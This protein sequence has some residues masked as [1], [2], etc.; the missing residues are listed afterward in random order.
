MESNRSIYIVKLNFPGSD[1]LD[2]I[3]FSSKKSIFDY[4]GEEIIGMTY[5]T[6]RNA[7]D[8]SP[9]DDELVTKYMTIHRYKFLMSKSPEIR[10]RLDILAN[11]ANKDMRPADKA[12]LRIEKLLGD[13]RFKNK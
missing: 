9:Y 5:K 8:N 6:Y 4:Y 11:R 3:A 7:W 12:M 13:E 10:V 2:N 1:V